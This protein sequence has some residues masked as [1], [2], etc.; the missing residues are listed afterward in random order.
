[1]KHRSAARNSA[2]L[3]SVAIQELRTDVPLSELSDAAVAELARELLDG[4]GRPDLMLELF[5]LS[6]CKRTWVGNSMV[7]GVSG[8]ERKRVST[9]EALMGGQQ[10]MLL[11]EISTG[12]VR[13]QLDFYLCNAFLHA[14]ALMLTG[15]PVSEW[16]THS[17][18]SVLPHR[19]CATF[20]RFVAR[21]GEYRSGIDQ[22]I[23]C[24]CRMRRRCSM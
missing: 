22:K 11:D 21:C 1:M 15:A 4:E 14:V 24:C 19:M 23:F 16:A 13:K 12:L 5:G 7:R 3:K 20:I 6:H 17:W 10:V 2:G 18:P 9:V 8:G